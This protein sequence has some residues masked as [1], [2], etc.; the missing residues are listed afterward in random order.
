MDEAR[1]MP[2]IRDADGSH[3]KLRRVQA[4]TGAGHTLLPSRALREMRWEP[5]PHDPPWGW[6]T[7][8]VYQAG[9]QAGDVKFQADE[10]DNSHSGILRADDCQPI[11]GEWSA[12]GF[13][14]DADGSNESDSPLRV[15]YR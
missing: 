4:N 5:D 6:P 12:T 14:R 15:I 9:L 13:V 1:A 11:L 8:L 3:A 7:S 2:G 10:R